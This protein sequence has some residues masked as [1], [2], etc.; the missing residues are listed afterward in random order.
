VFSKEMARMSERRWL[1]T[2]NA[3]SMRH[4]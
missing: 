1:P 3:I 2:C 4:S